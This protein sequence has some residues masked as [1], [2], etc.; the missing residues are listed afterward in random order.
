VDGGGGLWWGGTNK[1]AR[2]NLRE[3]KIKQRPKRGPMRIVDQRKG[4]WGMSSDQNGRI[5]I[6]LTKKKKTKK[7]KHARGR[8]TIRKKKRGG[9]SPPWKV[10]LRNRGEKEMRKL[11][12]KTQGA[13]RVGKKK[14]RQREVVLR[15]G[16]GWRAEDLAKRNMTGK[17]EKA[18]GETEAWTEGKVGH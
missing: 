8:R 2:K 18:R 15:R 13:K 1:S 11:E 4:L 6:H 10:I 7:Q 14:D 9:Q 5:K 16:G 12:R 3:K 17:G